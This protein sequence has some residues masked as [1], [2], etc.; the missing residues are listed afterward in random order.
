MTI[1]YSGL[2]IRPLETMEATAETTAPPLGDTAK[3]AA[4]G[5]AFGAGVGAGFWGIAM[6]AAN[7]LGFT[8][9]GI[10]AGST[11]ASWMSAAAVANGGGVAA[12]SA[13]SVLQSIGAVGLATPVGLGLVASGVVVGTAAVGIK[14][15]LS[16]GKVDVEGEQEPSEGADEET[17][18]TEEEQEAKT[19]SETPSWLLLEWLSATT[20]PVQT[21]FTS[22]CEAREAYKN[23][24]TTKKT[25]YHPDMTRAESSE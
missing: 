24:F 25:L 12:G 2:E 10:A 14:A 18:P 17:K 23:S 11:A 3:E 21:R 9:S 20:D 19:R 5:A 6:P 13:V 16:K 15:M 8:G 1:W 22:E 4:A 7:F